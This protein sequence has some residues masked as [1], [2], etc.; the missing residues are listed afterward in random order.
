MPERQFANDDASDLSLSDAPMMM[1]G[2]LAYFSSILLL[3]P[4]Q[5]SARWAN[6]STSLFL[7]LAARIYCSWHR[8]ICQDATTTTM[9][10]QWVA[11]FAVTDKRR[12]KGR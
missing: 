8:S 4:S 11:V 6:I 12:K 1:P 10:R 3:C 9:I 7:F 5:L 2:L